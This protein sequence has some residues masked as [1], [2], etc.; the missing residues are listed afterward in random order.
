MLGSGGIRRDE[1]QVDVRLLGRRQLDL[2]LLGGFLE[3]LN[4]HGILRKVDPL[5]LLE[6]RQEPLDDLLID[7]VT[8]QVRVTVG[9]LHLDD[10]FADLQDGNIE[11]TAAEVVDGDGLIG[12]L[13]QTVSQRR[14]GGLVDQP[15][16][17]E[18]GDAAGVLGGLTL[19][20]VEVRRN[21]D[22]GL[23]HRLAEVV[24]R[25]LLELLQHHGADFRRRVL[26]P[27]EG[28]ANIAVVRLGHLV[29]NHLH[30]F[31]DLREP[32]AHEALDRK[33]GVFGV[34]HGL[35]LGHLPHQA[36]PAGGKGH[37]G[38]RGAAP[39]GVWEWTL[40]SVP[41]MTETTLLVVPRSIPM[42]LLNLSPP[43]SAPF[44]EA[45][46][47]FDKSRADLLRNISKLG[48]RGITAWEA[49]GAPAF[50]R[51]EARSSVRVFGEGLHWNPPPRREGTN[52][53]A[54]L[55]TLNSSKYHTE[56]LIFIST[57]G[58]WMPGPEKW[59][60]SAEERQLRRACR[61]GSVEEDQGLFGESAE[62]RVE[63]EVQQE[64]AGD[65]LVAA[66][67]LHGLAA[68]HRG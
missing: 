9:G 12:L 38:R 3:T 54:L 28:D 45:L 37:H 6:L 43:S 65:G 33:Y 50:N 21:R 8:A 23:F 49:A 25:R 14:G 11:S 15:L 4:R 53:S 64:V 17:L 7:V 20:V 36:L 67:L 30:L 55:S 22:D 34:G 39:L 48:F 51:R 40:G 32:A 31:V 1:R 16:H 35:A 62:I 2:G 41:S 61:G 47:I 57:A 42:I 24:L 56:R 13:V 19:R 52:I 46:E 18:A 66:Q 44:G 58:S 68:G 10:A 59:A 29:G 63:V 27:F 60:A 5:I 26:L